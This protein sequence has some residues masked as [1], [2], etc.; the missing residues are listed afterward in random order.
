[1]LILLIVSALVFDL[2]NGFHDSSN[3]V[4]TVISSRALRP[5]VALLLTAFAHFVAPFLFGVA[6]AET[7]GN[8]LI[9]PKA[10]T[11]VVT[12]AAI[13]SAIIW[14]LVTW[15]FGIPSSSSH[16]LVGG[17]VGA[18]ILSEGL[19]VVNLN[20]LFWI[21]FA[22]F[23]SPPLGLAT[24]YIIMHVTQFIFKSASPKVNIFFKR[25]QIV[26]SLS[27]A[28]SHG[29]NDAQKTMGLITMGLVSSGIQN[30]F[31]VPLW[32]VFLS[33]GAIALGTAL[34]GW[35]LI[36]TLGGKIYKIRP[37][38]A[39]VS[40][41]A[42]SL[43]IFGASFLGGPVSTTQV[44]SSTIMGAGAAERLS[45]VRWLVA[46]N[47]FVIWLLTIPLTAILSAGIYLLLNKLF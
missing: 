3:I 38:H 12:T 13:F 19:K 22:L 25:A 24:S 9:D 34:G 41:S 20:G 40:Q 47:M 11:D 26:T 30:T 31:V 44:V 2:L 6:V 21:L 1:M 18:A 36:H 28:L 15:Y 33:A 10:V 17:L 42:S 43:V 46:Q 39:F 45:K 32:V 5:R 8:E 16:A 35:R 4:A 27:L 29:T 37:V 23:I 7:I 14:N